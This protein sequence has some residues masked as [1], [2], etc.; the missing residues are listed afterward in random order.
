VDPKDIHRM[1]RFEIYD[2][3]KSLYERGIRYIEEGNVDEGIQTLELLLD[4]DP[5]YEA[6]RKKL[7]EIYG[8]K[9]GVLREKKGRRTKREAPDGVIPEEMDY[10]LREPTELERGEIEFYLSIDKDSLLIMLGQSSTGALGAEYS[11]ATAKKKGTEWL[12]RARKQLR[13]KICDEWAYCDRRNEERLKDDVILATA[14]G[15][16]IITIAR[17]IPPL[18]IACLLVKMG[19]D[20]FCGCKKV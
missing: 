6:A 16:R 4:A 12:N 3:R 1:D 19:L 2:S 11:P 10:Q 20:E 7:A 8:K 17:K 15:G 5:E 14:I 13:R 18:A 9:L